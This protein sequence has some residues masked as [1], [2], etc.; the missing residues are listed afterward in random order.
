MLRFEGHNYFRQRLLLATLSNKPVRI[1]KIRSDDE[2]R[3]GL[4]DYEASFLRLLEKVTNGAVVEISYTGTTVVY[5]PG[6]IIGGKVRH[7]CPPSRAIGYFLEPLIALAPFAKHPLQ[8]TLSGVTNDNVDLSVDAIRTVLLPHLKRFGV[9]DG[10]EM[11]ITKRGAPPKGGG[12][13]FFQC[14]IVRQL[15]PVQFIEEGKFKRIRGIAY[16][17]RVSPQMANRVVETSRSMMTRYIPDVYIYTDVY[18][19]AESGQSPGY[20][21]TIVAESTTGAL[22]SAECAFQPRKPANAD[23]ETNI[24]SRREDDALANDYHFQT[25]EDLGAFTGRKLL[26]EIEKG[27]CFDT[28]SQWLGALFLALGPEDVGKI[29][30]GALSPFTIQYLRDIKSFLGITFKVTPDHSNQTV[31]LTCLG[32]G[33]TNTNKKVT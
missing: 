22:L 7:E 32:M 9:E 10:L 26:Q 20:A 23:V 27:G 12:E 30:V 15:K 18:K 19:G 11:K 8:L 31:L 14:P 6:L 17:T 3:P 16:A 28:S 1:D 33:Y 13:I 5:R 25:P 24:V 29:R 21:L 4:S 2:D